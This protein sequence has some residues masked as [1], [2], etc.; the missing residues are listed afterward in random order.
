MNFRKQI[1]AMILTCM[2]AIG[3]TA[4]ESN[5]AAGNKSSKPSANMNIVDDSEKTEQS[6]NASKTEPEAPKIIELNNTYTT[7][8]GEVNA[9]DYPP[10]VFNYPD[11]WT[12]SQEEV[13]TQDNYSPTHEM[14]TLENDRGVKITYA[15]FSSSVDVQG[16]SMAVML[17]VDVSKAA[18]SDFVPSYVQAA[19]HSKLGAFIVGK[20]KE[21]GSMNMQSESEFTDIDG[22]VSYAVLP[23]TQIGTTTTR[24]AFLGEFSFDYSGHISFIA[25]APKG[26][27]TAQE[28]REVIAILSTFRIEPISYSPEASSQQQAVVVDTP[29]QTVPNTQ[30]SAPDNSQ[31]SSNQGVAPNGFIDNG[32]GTWTDPATGQNKLILDENGNIVGSLVVDDDGG[33]L[34]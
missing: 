27:F 14:V 23:E 30:A 20:L 10:F 8:F 34:S 32:D 2:I 24:G 33:G 12:I 26:E 25:E 4:C 31:N 6:S 7:R 5:Q 13:T 3:F 15:H 11:N 21:T 22:S 19:D 9:I 16:T 17:R 29:Q 1:F 28:E 18:D